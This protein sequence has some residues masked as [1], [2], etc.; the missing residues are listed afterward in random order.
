MDN[1]KCVYCTY[2]GIVVDDPLQR[3]QC[4]WQPNEEN[5]YSLPCEIDEDE[6]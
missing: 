3:L 6:E 2:Y 4:L 5:G 1:K